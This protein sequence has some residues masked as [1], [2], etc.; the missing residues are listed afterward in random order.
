[1]FAFD[2]LFSVATVLTL[3]SPAFESVFTVPASTVWTKEKTAN[4]KKKTRTKKE[5]RRKTRIMKGGE[6]RTNHT[7]TFIL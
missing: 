6:N 3:L 2:T 5:E 4:E 7:G 1:M